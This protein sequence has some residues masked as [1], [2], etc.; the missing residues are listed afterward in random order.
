MRVRCR[1]EGDVEMWGGRIGTETLKKGGLVGPREVHQ[2]S[3]SSSS[4]SIY[5]L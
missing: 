3:S 2:L 1:A 5:A 4:S